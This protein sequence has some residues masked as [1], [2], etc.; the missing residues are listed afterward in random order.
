[1]SFQA[2]YE[3]RLLENSDIVLHMP[4]LYE[5]A[6]GRQVIELGVRSG[7]STAAFLAAQET[8]GGHLW[9]VD[10]DWPHVPPHWVDSDGWDFLLGNDLTL[11]DELPDDVDVVFIDTSHAY[12]QTLG[13][14]YLYANKLKA[15]GVILLHDTE[16]EHPEA[17]PDG[18][19]FPVRRAVDEFAAEVG[20]KTEFHAGCNG[21]GVIYKP[22]A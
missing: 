6:G 10:V 3:A 16:L 8:S 18:M 13:E 11:A 14:L 2:E 21:L 15:G 19:P 20:W 17:Q 12:A 4:A 5:A 9:S 22:E 7:N 1:M